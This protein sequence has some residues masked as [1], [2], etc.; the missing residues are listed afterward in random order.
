MRTNLDEHK[1]GMAY[2]TC[3]HRVFY[4]TNFSNSLGLVGRWLEPDGEIGKESRIGTRKKSITRAPE[5]DLVR[6]EQS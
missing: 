1:F 6:K 5:Y 4:L 3:D 2:R